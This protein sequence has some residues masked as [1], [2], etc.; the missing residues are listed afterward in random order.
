MPYKDD[1]W[2]NFQKNNPGASRAQ[3]IKSLIARPDTR[4][5]ADRVS[6]R[7]LRPLPQ[8]PDPRPLADRVSERVIPEGYTVGPAERALEDR[9]M[10]DTTWKDITRTPLTDIDDQ[11]NKPVAPVG[12]GHTYVSPGKGGYSGGGG[13]GLKISGR[14]N[15][16]TM[17]RKTWKP[18]GKVSNSSSV[19]V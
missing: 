19:N 11:I 18:L 9:G 14:T 5:L 4:P 2:I 15:T 1:A 3:H 6:D 7:A 16:N 12:A 13:A 10:V 17:K 8:K